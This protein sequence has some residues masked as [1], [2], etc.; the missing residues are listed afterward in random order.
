MAKATIALA[1][2][3]QVQIDGTPEEIARLMGLYNGGSDPPTS[4]RGP[5]PAKRGRS[6]TPVNKPGTADAPVDHVAIINAIKES[7]EF[8]L[9]EARILEQTS[10]VDRTLLPLYAAHE[11][12][13]PNMTLTSGDIAKV[14]TDLGNPV[15]MPN[16]SKVLAGSASRFV[17]ADGVRRTGTPV[18]YRIHRRGVQYLKAILQAG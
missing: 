2:G 10:Q 5:K 18:G 4:L 1:N 16:V 3:T 9:I 6:K 14:L 7:D 15:S 8:D 17:I 13:D 12:V 11:H